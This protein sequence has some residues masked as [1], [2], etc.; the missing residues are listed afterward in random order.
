MTYIELLHLLGNE[1]TRDVIGS[2]SEIF[3]TTFYILIVCY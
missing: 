1:E 2:Q 3:T